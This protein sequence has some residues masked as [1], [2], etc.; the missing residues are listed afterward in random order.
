MGCSYRRQAS[1][2]PASYY[3]WLRPG[4]AAVNRKPKRMYRSQ[5][6]HQ[7][8]SLR[9]GGLLLF[10]VTL[11]NGK[12]FHILKIWKEMNQIKIFLL[13]IRF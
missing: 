12:M 3:Q 6:P 4:P 13:F 9:A 1:A 11:H 2:R 10:G 5:G 7:D 8:T